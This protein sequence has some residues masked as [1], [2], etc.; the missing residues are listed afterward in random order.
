MLHFFKRLLLWGI[1]YCV[2]LCALQDVLLFPGACEALLFIRSLPPPK[3]ADS[4]WVETSDHKRI[5][6]WRVQA[7]EPARGVAIFFHGNGGSMLNF[8]TYQTWLASLGVTSY[9]FDYRGYGISTGWP[10]SAGMLLDGE[11]VIAE[12]S[13]REGI[14]PSQIIFVGT[15]LGTG[16]AAELA[17]KSESRMLVLLSPYSELKQRVREEAIAGYLSPFLRHNFQTRRAVQALPPGCLVIAHGEADDIID[18]HHSRE[19]VSS[20]PAHL[21]VESVFLPG[22]GHNDLMMKSAQEVTAL[23]EHCLQ[24][25]TGN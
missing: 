4:I 22:V 11:A 2:A 10:S 12:I 25:A 8:F 18:A 5:N 19:I 21:Q 1:A 14:S 24:R 3:E 17:A 16:P 9:A 15:S 6:V 23:V 7:R 13:K 20:A